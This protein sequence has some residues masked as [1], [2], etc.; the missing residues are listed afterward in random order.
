MC[1]NCCCAE[2]GIHDDLALPVEEPARF[3]VFGHGVEVEIVPDDEDSGTIIVRLDVDEAL[4]E[5]P[6]RLIHDIRKRRLS[7]TKLK[8]RLD[9]YA[10]LKA[11]HAVGVHEI[12]LR[13]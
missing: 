12:P 5:F 10:E 9:R 2:T 13:N 8:E 11:L 1:K 7:K 3:R 6:A 4:S